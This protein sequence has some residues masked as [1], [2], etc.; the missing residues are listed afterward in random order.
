MDPETGSQPADASG[1]I[2]KVSLASQYALCKNSFNKLL[3][4][5][6]TLDDQAVTEKLLDEFGKFRV[7]GGNTGAHR[8]GRDSLDYRLREAP[9]IHEKLTRFLDELNKNLEEGGF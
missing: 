3:Q 9:H 5:L 7:W 1:P 8:T 4:N 2:V 6:K